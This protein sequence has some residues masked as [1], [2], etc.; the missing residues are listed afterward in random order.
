[1][2]ERP[3]DRMV[4][5]VGEKQDR[6]LRA[7]GRSGGNWSAIAVL[8]VIGW[9]VVV[10]TLGGIALGV[11]LDRTWPSRVSWTV[12]LL[13]IGLVAGCANAWLRVRENR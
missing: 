9:S 13:L 8:G 7:R 4:R 6:M 10:P 2:A 1:M 3:E 11:W 12:T 5:N